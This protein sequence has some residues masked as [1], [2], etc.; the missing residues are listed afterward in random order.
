MNKQFHNVGLLIHLC[1][2]T[3]LT[4]YASHKFG[5][6]SQTQSCLFPSCPLV[7]SWSS[8]CPCSPARKGHI[9]VSKDDA[10]ITWAITTL[11]LT[12]RWQE[13]FSQPKYLQLFRAPGD[14]SPRSTILL[15]LIIHKICIRWSEGKAKYG[16]KWTWGFRAKFFLGAERIVFMFLSWQ[17]VSFTSTISPRSAT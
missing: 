9:H 12:L 4:L 7:Y 1:Q 6:Y 8:W 3:W 17:T 14:G 2:R 15:K 10:S 16:G 5:E 11:L 13:F